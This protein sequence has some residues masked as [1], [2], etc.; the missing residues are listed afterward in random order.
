MSDDRDKQS[1]STGGWALG[2]VF[3]LVIYLLAPGPAIYML[4]KGIL[5][6][7]GPALG[8]L[9]AL[10]DPWFDVVEHVK[11]LK[12]SYEHYFKFWDSL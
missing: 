9:R 10:Y 5:S 3:A 2:V 8:V 7:T 12:R 11:P 4:R 1:S 6:E